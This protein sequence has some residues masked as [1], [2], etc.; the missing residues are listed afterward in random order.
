MTFVFQQKF[1][2]ISLLEKQSSYHF[3]YTIGIDCKKEKAWE[4]SIKVSDWNNWDT[5]FGNFKI[6]N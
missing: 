1:S 6:T 3:L 4:L 2:E 5:E